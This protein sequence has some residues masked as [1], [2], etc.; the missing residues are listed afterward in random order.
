VRRMILVGSLLCSVLLLMGALK[1]LAAPGS[2]AAP[3][4]A[5]AGSGGAVSLEACLTCTRATDPRDCHTLA[6]RLAEERDW[7]NSIAVEERVHAQL[8]NDPEVAAALG[9][10]HQFGSKD[11]ARATEMYHTALAAS[12]GYPPALFG[13]GTLMQERGKTEIAARYFARGAKERPEM[14]LFKVRLAETLVELGRDTEARPLL[15][16]VVQRFPGTP[17]ADAAGRMMNRPALARP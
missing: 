6:L 1:A 16:E 7:K 10:M 11:V 12:P 2:K 15:E 3:R 4:G 5:Q 13:L 14:A 17:E 9:R 8:P